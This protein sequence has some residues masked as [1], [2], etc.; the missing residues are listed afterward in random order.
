MVRNTAER[1]PARMRWL[2]CFVVIASFSVAACVSDDSTGTPD[3]GKPDATAD[4]GAANDVNVADVAPDATDAAP[5]RYCAT[6]SPPDGAA[7]FTCADFDGTNL[8]EGFTDASVSEGGSL[9]ANNLAFV[10]SPNGLLA[11]TPAGADGDQLQALYYWLQP[12]GKRVHTITLTM[13]VNP[14]PNGT[15]PPQITGE[16]VLASMPTSVGMIAFGYTRNNQHVNALNGYSGYY[17]E[18]YRSK[19]PPSVAYTE[20]A[21]LTENI[22]TEVSITLD[23]EGQTMSLDYD[24]APQLPANTAIVFA[25]TE[26]V[27]TTYVGIATQDQTPLF[28]F[29][30]DNV[31]IWTTRDP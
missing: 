2:L 30:F 18:T 24:G 16:V 19:S 22:W 10:S 6:Q 12:G 13:S 7:D 14:F 4:D 1:Y 26:T 25:A 27:A 20:V 28:N 8:G 31:R 29:R 23:E 11:T 9:A 17:M 5:P 21:P 3:S 15:L